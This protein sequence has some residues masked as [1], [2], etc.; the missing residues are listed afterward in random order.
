MIPITPLSSL[1]FRRRDSEPRT[2]EGENGGKPYAGRWVARLGE[3]VVGQGGTPQQA[4]QAAKAAR[5]KETPQVI[6]V[7]TTN[8]F[9]FS[10]LLELIRSALPSDTLVYLV[11]G[12]V[13]DAL[14]ERP[15]HDYDFALPGDALLAARRVANKIGAA[16]FPLDADRGTARLIFTDEQGSR[17]V[18]DF[19]SLR[20][21]D[22]ES[23]LRARDFTVNALA[24][25]VRNPQALLDP[26][27][28]AA[29]VWNKALRACSP[30][31]FTGD[32]VRILRAIRIAAGFGFHILPETRKFMR[33]A[34][35]LLPRVSP[36]RLRDELFRILGGPQPHTAIRALDMLGVLPHILPE[37]LSVK[38][39][40]QSPPHVRDVWG[41]TLDTMRHLDI[42]LTVLGPRHDPD[43]SANLTLGVAVM[44]LGR[45]RQQ[46]SAYLQAPLVPE[47]PLRPLLFLAALYH[48]IGKPEVRHLDENGRIRFFNHE[49]IGEELVSG[50]GKALHLSNTEIDRLGAVVRH[51]MRPTLL[52]HSER[53]PSSR[54]IYRF[55]RATGIA[56]V[57]ICLLSLA[58][59][60][61]TYGTM[62]PQERWAR[63]VNVVGA[64]LEAW[65]EHPETKVYPPA[66]ITG[67]DLISEFGLEPGPLIGELL[68]GVREAQAVGDVGSREAA[69]AL[70]RAYLGD[71]KIGNG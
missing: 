30:T 13:R 52:A 10:S 69:L 6:Y 4:L 70:V 55:F 40:T 25:D 56:G 34:V 21:P 68:E 61:A 41:H 22:L 17:H 1:H 50:R 46:I 48:D 65:W 26:L 3:R 14:L 62:L 64:L 35:P 16:Y 37:L 57:D 20:G 11:G 43:A 38:N 53:G 9:E 32:P 39:V 36:E 27:G 23:D 15:V 51:H 28:G 12:A 2:F 45:Y 54:A 58:D 71:E 19:A 59:L 29:D 8:P 47:R 7:P 5:H 33:D 31:S 66:V 42:L 67:H 18:L 44:R 49:Q 60:L 63:Q 24:V